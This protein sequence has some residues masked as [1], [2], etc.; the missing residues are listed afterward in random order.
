MSLREAEFTGRQAIC[1]VYCISTGF[2][3]RSV[4]SICALLNRKNLYKGIVLP[5]AQ[6]DYAVGPFALIVWKYVVRCCCHCCCS[7]AAE[8]PIQGRQ[9]TRAHV[10]SIGSQ[11]FAGLRTGAATTESS[12]GRRSNT[13]FS[14]PD[15]PGVPIAR[16]EA[17]HFS[18]AAKGKGR[19]TVPAPSKYSFGTLEREKR[20]AGPSTTAHDVPALE[21][22]TAPH[23]QSFD[24]LFQGALDADR[25][26]LPGSAGK[27]L[28]ELAVKDITH[29]VIFDGKGTAN[30]KLGNKVECT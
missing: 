19:A 2:S 21:E 29:K 13:G 4:L 11:V 24:A 17:A 16:P 7:R 10:Q 23:I 9:C 12:S 18:A 27:G 30:G 8:S 1:V 14:I 20:F 25:K 6:R 26:P 22:L 5:E 28:L 15:M 3:M